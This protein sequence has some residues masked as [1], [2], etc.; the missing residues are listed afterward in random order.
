MQHF[1]FLVERNN[2]AIILAGE[3]A[4]LMSISMGS[5]PILRFVIFSPPAVLIGYHQS[6]EQEVN[7]EEVKKRG[8][9]IGRR[10]TGGGTIIMRPWQL[11]WEI[12][13]EKVS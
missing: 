7:I 10:P 11:G 3:E 4:L 2:Q 12:Y 1:R 8:R 9:E 13:A 6:V 5:S